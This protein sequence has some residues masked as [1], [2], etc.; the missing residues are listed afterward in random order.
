MNRR[1]F[2]GLTIGTGASASAL[3]VFGAP[4]LL[5][6][7]G[8]AGATAGAVIPEWIAATPAT[9]YRPYTSKVAANAGAGAWV[10]VDLSSR[11]QA[12]PLLPGIRSPN[13]TG[14]GKLGSGKTG[15]GN[16]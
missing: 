12:V 16:S 9:H 11:L 15:K 13:V 2:L 8:D 5:A 7:A 4:A 6:A 1:K 14:A 3:H 10:Q